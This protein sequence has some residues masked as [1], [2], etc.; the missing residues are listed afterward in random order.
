[1]IML[2][3][4][5][6]FVFLNNRKYKINVDFRNMIS[7]EQIVQ[8]RTKS[9]AEKI[10]E[11]IQLFYP[12]FSKDIDF[13]YLQRNP[14][15]YKLA[16]DKLVWFYKCGRKDYSSSQ[17]KNNSKDVPINRIY[18]YE[19]DDEYIY[20]AFYQEYGIDLSYQRV[21]WWKF[22]ALL[23]SLKED[24]VFEKIQGY[25]AYSGDDENIK[26]LKEYYNLPLPESEQKRLD[27][28][29]ESLV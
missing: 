22:K 23:K 29:F 24:V 2:R 15:L 11:G 12:A 13:Y 5:P 14:N 16:C 9:K 3:R 21:H 19:Y 27:A 18:S 20:G 1:M 10:K 17:S 4:L 28:L 7:F 6:Y 26:A 25:R 8:D